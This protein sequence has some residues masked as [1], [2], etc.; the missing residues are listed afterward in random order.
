[1]RVVTLM[2]VILCCCYT[3]SRDQHITR[4]TVVLNDNRR[5]ENVQLDRDPFSEAVEVTESSGVF[6]S[7]AAG[8]ILYTSYQGGDWH[9]GPMA[10]AAILVI[11][12]CAIGTVGSF[13]FRTTGRMRPSDLVFWLNVG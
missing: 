12:S 13:L 5:V 10:W 3:I 1:M 4:A 2:I 6:Y 8:S 7:I 11:L 9:V